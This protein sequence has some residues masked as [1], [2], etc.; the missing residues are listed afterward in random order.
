MVSRF[1][2]NI[3]DQRCKK[4]VNKLF[5]VRNRP[6]N[7]NHTTH[8]H[9]RTHLLL[10]RHLSHADADTDHLPGLDSSEA[11]AQAFWTD[12]CRGVHVGS[13]GVISAL[14]PEASLPVV[15]CAG[16][17][18]A[19]ANLLQGAAVGAEDATCRHQIQDIVLAAAA[20][21]SVNQTYN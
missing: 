21:K 10:G 17:L 18:V 2:L 15:H 12:N 11:G 1:K 14:T 9:T 13:G 19:V 20:N 7:V 16:V 4:R 5:K 6:I 3:L 8:T